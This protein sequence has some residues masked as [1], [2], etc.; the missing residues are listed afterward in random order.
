MTG[1]SLQEF[2]DQMA[3]I[4]PMMMREFF[5]HQT[6][7]FYKTRLTMPQFAV[8]DIINRSGR[9]K[10]SD[11]AGIMHVTTAAATGIIDRLFRDGYIKR[12][13]DPED[14]RIVMVRLTA[15]GAAVI[16]DAVEKRKK[17]TIKIFGMISQEERE[18]YLKIL[19][20]IA[21]HLK[22]QE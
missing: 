22:G 13:T 5:K 6:S 16:N 12:E 2:A 19:K 7:K 17:M 18:E 10:M 20:H 14:R 4:M 11:L 15:K 8:L 1:L 9:L 21:E 3:E